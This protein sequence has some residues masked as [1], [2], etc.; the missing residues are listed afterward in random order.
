MEDLSLRSIVMEGR[1]GSYLYGTATSS[2]DE[3]FVGVFLPMVKE[4]LGLK[5][6]DEIDTSSKSSS[7]Q[8]RNTADDVDFKYYSI[9]KFIRLL[10][11]N[12]P[13]IVEM[14][15]INKENTKINSPYWE[16]LQENYDKFIS[17]RVQKSFLGYAFSQKEKLLIKKAR[18][19]GLCEAVQYLSDL[20][21]PDELQDTQRQICEIIAKSL[22]K[23]VVHYKGSKGNTE[24][25]HSGLPLKTIYEK[26]KEE[27][28]SY[29]WRVKTESFDKVGYDVKYAYH[30]IRLMHEAKEL[31]TKGYLTFPLPDGILQTI[32][33]IRNC[34]WDLDRIIEEYNKMYAE[35]KSLSFTIRKNPDRSWANTFLINTQ[36]YHIVSTTVRRFN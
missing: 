22:N 24:S 13:N 3:D 23:M 10:L 27:R 26:L 35:V 12:N 17:L 32:D 30:L 20:F 34:E 15:F 16:E 2:S 25:F 14:L 19:E 8:R 21:E 11:Q 4:L 6:V 5:V 1:T 33:K 36:L 28:D 9:E 31:L 18:Y 29:G 7:S